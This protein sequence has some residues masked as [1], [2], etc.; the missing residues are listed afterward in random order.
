MIRLQSGIAY[1]YRILPDC[2][3]VPKDLGARGIGAIAPPEKTHR[4][5]VDTS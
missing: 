2:A 3:C 1:P 5:S 4:L